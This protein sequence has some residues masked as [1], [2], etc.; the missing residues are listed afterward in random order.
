MPLGQDAEDDAMLVLQHD[1]NGKDIDATLHLGAYFI[2]KSGYLQAGRY[3]KA[4][5]LLDSRPPPTVN[6]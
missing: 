4:V 5:L 6:S 1:K 2:G 3:A